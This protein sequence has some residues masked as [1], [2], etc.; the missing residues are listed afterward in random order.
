MLTKESIQNYEKK[1]LKN[2]D[3]AFSSQKLLKAFILKLN[4]KLINICFRIKIPFK[5]FSY[6]CTKSEWKKESEI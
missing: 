6:V 2:V 1:N 4:H 5:P 3:E